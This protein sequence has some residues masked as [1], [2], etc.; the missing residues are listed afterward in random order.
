MTKLRI[1]HDNAKRS[2][3]LTSNVKLSTS[4]P[5]SL[6]T[7]AELVEREPGNEVDHFHQDVDA[8]NLK[9]FSGF[10]RVVCFLK[11]QEALNAVFEL[12][13]QQYSF[14]VKVL[15]DHALLLKDIAVLNQEGL[16]SNCLCKSLNV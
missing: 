13:G 1:A 6:S 11:I 16:A 10:V 2:R 8:K 9:C 3:P 7:E 5:G 15:H 12:M 4:L 14:L